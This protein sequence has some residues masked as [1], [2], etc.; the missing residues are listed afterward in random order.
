MQILR[1]VNICIPKGK[2]SSKEDSSG[3]VQSL[4]VTLG[5]P[6]GSKVTTATG[7]VSVTFVS[8]LKPPYMQ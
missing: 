6:M 2:S 3:R 7:K 1:C 4:K 5:G 8:V